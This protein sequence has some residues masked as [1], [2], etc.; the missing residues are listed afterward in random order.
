MLKKPF[1]NASLL[2]CALLA[3]PFLSCDPQGQDQGKV[4]AAPFIWENASIY[5]LLTDRFSNGDP[6]NDINFDRT[7]QTAILRGFEGGDMAGVIRKI[8]EGYFDDL[9]ITALW[10]TPWF[11][12]VHGSTDEGTG[13][14]YGYHGYWAKDWT[15]IEPNFGNPETLSLLVETAHAHGIRIVMDIVINHTGPVTPLDPAWPDEWVRKSPRCVY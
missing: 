4:P 7:D 15:A 5:F 2:L 8:E 14:T 3:S 10:L 12:Q 11:E 13:P 9:G 6:S 1:L